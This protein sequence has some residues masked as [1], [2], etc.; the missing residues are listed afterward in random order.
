[1]SLIDYTVDNLV[2]QV[3][4]SENLQDASQAFTDN[5]IIEFMNEELQITVVPIVESVRESYFTVT[6]DF[7]FLNN[8][9]NNNVIPIPNEATGLRL[10][11]VFVIDSSA[12]FYNLPLLTATQAAGYSN[13]WN[14]GN[15]SPAW[16]F[17]NAGFYVQ[18]NNLELYPYTIAAGN[19]F[20]LLYH[21]K[22]NQLVGSSNSGQII[23]INVISGLLTM[24]NIP[25]YWDANIKLDFIQSTPTFDFVP[26]AFVTNLVY[27]TPATL[28]NQPVTQ[29]PNANTVF[30]DPLIAD[31]LSVGQYV[32]ET[33]TAPVVQY[34]PTDIYPLLK[35]STA[36][37]CLRA[38]NDIE[39]EQMAIQKFKQMATNVVNNLTSP[40]VEDKPKKIIPQN[41]VGRSS[42]ISSGRWGY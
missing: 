1:M 7:V 33:G 22:P 37:R 31:Q 40:R 5:D 13:V 21:R 28:T 41:S 23:A 16:N 19:T 34:L 3:R 8:N 18:G 9:S 17:G 35:E 42:R 10:Q 39:A 11:N 14:A 6:K 25:S 2:A 27:S 29:A 4:L 38:L 20:R 24:N 36:I 12:Q 15:N 32:T 26:N 30:V